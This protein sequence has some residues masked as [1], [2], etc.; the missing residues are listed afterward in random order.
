MDEKQDKAKSQWLW[1]PEQGNRVPEQKQQ[2]TRAIEQDTST[3]KWC[4]NH[5]CQ[6]MTGSADLQ[7][8]CI[9]IGSWDA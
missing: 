9:Q 1:V 2:G 7:R 8:S 4:S 3:G 6:T 5:T